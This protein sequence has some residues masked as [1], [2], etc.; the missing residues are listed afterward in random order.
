MDKTQNLREIRNKAIDRSYG[1]VAGGGIRA[2][3]DVSPSLPKKDIYSIGPL[4]QPKMAERIVAALVDYISSANLE[5]GHKLPSEKELSEILQVGNRSLREALMILQAL[6]LVQSRH[7]AGWFVEEFDPTSSL[8]ILSPVFEKFGGGD[9][10]QIL[11][12]RLTIEPQV[13]YLAAEHISEGGLDKLSR[14]MNQM[15]EL[16]E[17]IM[18]EK[19]YNETYMAYGR[20]DQAFHVILSQECA[21]TILAMLSTILSETFDVVRFRMFMVRVEEPLQQ[22]QAIYD[23][24]CRHDSRAAEEAMRLHIEDTRQ[25]FRNH[26]HLLQ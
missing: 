2:A 5:P 25:L 26:R 16:G 9:V 3:R 17:R 14:A 24:V 10:F 13:A 6:G 22:H 18:R 12:T 15:K 20:H 8:R 19:Q 7:G 21:N 11:D 4:S 1:T 23:A